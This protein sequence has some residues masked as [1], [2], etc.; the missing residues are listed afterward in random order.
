MSL[1][2][3]TSSIDTVTASRDL[4]I[5]TPLTAPGQSLN[6]PWPAPS[7]CGITTPVTGKGL[8][9]A[10]ITFPG[11]LRMAKEGQGE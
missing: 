10:G 3:K 2:I 11:T 9:T 8:R 1:D 6:Q 5:P 4:L 7:H